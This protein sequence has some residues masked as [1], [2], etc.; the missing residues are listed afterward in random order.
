MT[1]F[2][3]EA[4]SKVVL[5]A[6]KSDLKLVVDLERVI[7][8]SSIVETD[9]I[10]P[11]EETLFAYRDGREYPSRVTVGCS[12]VEVTT[13]AL[14]AKQAF[15]K[16]PECAILAGKYCLITAWIGL[17]DK[18]TT[19]EPWDP[20]CLEN[21]ELGKQALLYWSKTCINT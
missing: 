16:P 4:I 19:P 5:P 20:K 14:I 1:S 15:G 11:D 17:I 9:T 21:K 12:G 18:E 6:D 7:G 13:V 3:E 2:L 8:Q 10:S